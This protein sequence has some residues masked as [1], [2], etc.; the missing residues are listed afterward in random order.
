MTSVIYA[1]IRTTTTW[2]LDAPSPAKNEPQPE[3][4]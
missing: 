3:L 4:V 1:Y 2:T